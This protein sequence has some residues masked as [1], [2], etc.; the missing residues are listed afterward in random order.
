MTAQ[1]GSVV[2]LQIDRR[3]SRAMKPAGLRESRLSRMTRCIC[4]SHGQQTRRA[5]F[6][7]GGRQRSDQSHPMTSVAKI[8]GTCRTCRQKLKRSGGGTPKGT[9][10]GPP[11]GHHPL[12]FVTSFSCCLCLLPT[13]TYVCAYRYVCTSVARQ[14][15]NYRVGKRAGEAGV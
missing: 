1:T 15:W 3:L 2:C 10:A 9:S 7:L 5:G 12:G 11:L 4:S 8:S 6:E 14:Q 13:H